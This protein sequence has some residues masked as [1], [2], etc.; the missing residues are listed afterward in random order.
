[1][2]P[3]VKF[4]PN[5]ND[6][7]VSRER[8]QL[9]D[10]SRL[11]SLLPIMSHH[12]VADIGCGPGYFSIPLA[13]YLF[14][15]KLFALDVQ[16]EMLDAT[17]KALKAAR[18]TNT[19]LI[20]SK[21]TKIPIED[22]VLDGAITSFVLQEASRPSVLLKEA[23]RCL[24]KSGWLIILEW[25]KREMDEGPPL[26]QRISEDELRKMTDKL[27]FRFRALRNL[28]SSQYMMLVRK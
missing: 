28:N 13:K 9:I 1:M 26:S 4:D 24:K 23:K 2:T 21:E 8:R 19:E 12:W 6:I 3:K 20:L 25:H 5:D 18:L 11:I 16:K 27:G 10:P 15:G 7:L 17:Q 14:D 22:E